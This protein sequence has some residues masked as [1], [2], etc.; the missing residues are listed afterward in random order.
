M[1]VH[2][3]LACSFEWQRVSRS[4]LG[5]GCNCTQDTHIHHIAQKKQ[6]ANHQDSNSF[7]QRHKWKEDEKRKKRLTGFFSGNW[8][9]PKAYI[10]CYEVHSKVIQKPLQL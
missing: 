10:R 9:K 2:R 6:C 3:M 8:M 7:R 5:L 1:R 4:R